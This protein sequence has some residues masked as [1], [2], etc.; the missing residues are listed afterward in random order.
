MIDAL[1]RVVVSLLTFV[2]SAYALMTAWSAF[3]VFVLG[4]VEAKWGG[5]RDSFQI[6]LYFAALFVAVFAVGWLVGWLVTNWWLAPLRLSGEVKVAALG[7]AVVV[8]VAVTGVLGWL[9]KQ[10]P[11]DFGPLVTVLVLWAAAVRLVLHRLLLS[12]WRAN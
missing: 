6:G 9:T 3:D 7:A 12:R 10:L 11:G 1:K 4:N 8:A 2:V 5:P